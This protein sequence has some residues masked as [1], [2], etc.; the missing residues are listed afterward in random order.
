MSSVAD[1]A[2][3]LGDRQTGGYADYASIGSNLRLQAGTNI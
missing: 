1:F 2:L 3:T